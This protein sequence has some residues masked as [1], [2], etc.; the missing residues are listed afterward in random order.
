MY[1]IGQFSVMFQLNKKT[2]RYYDEINL[3][4]PAFVDD[5]NQYR[6][7]EESQIEELKEI[8]RLKDIGIPLDKISKIMRN[9]NNKEKMECYSERL[10]EIETQQHMLERQ[11]ELILG[12]QNK[13]EPQKKLYVF[14]IQKGYFI[15]KGFI[16]FMNINC[17]ME[18]IN[19]YISLFYEN[20]RGITLNSSHIFKMNTDE[21]TDSI[22][23]IFAY[24][25]EEKGD[26]VR[27]QE[28][29]LC[30]MTECHDMNQKVNGYQALF[31]YVERNN[32]L[33]KD[34]YEKYQIEKGRMH[35]IIIFSIE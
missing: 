17:E 24:T 23:E 3:F 11:K 32:L 30:I 7:Y 18:D 13:N 20:A 15:N 29:K 8:I 1:S 34:I 12:Y 10:H 31:N 33:V 4:K 2:L 21:D 19:R 16:Y 9:K 28:Q 27:L 25:N 14:D 6:Y 22:S 35:V 26:K 5:N